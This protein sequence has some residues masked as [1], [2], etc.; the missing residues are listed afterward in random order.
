MDLIY[1]VEDIFSKY[2]PSGKHFVIPSYQRGYKWK[3]KDIEQLLNDIDSFQTH[4]NSTV[5]YCLQ[6]I[7]LVKNGDGNYNVVDG[8]QRLTTLTLLLAHLNKS[9]LVEGKLQYD[10]R[11]ETMR[12]LTE[13]VLNRNL[14]GFRSNK[15][16]PNIL[17]LEWNELGIADDDEYNFQ[18]IFYMYNACKTIEE[19]FR[20]HPDKTDVMREKIL[21]NVKLIVNLPQ[22]STLQEYDLFDN[23]NGKRVTLDGAD[24]IRAMI[25]TRA[26]RKEVENID[27][28][29]KHDVILNE[30]RVKNGLILDDINAWWS[31]K[32]RQAYF[33]QFTKNINSRGENIQFEDSQYPIDFLYKLIVQT[34]DGQKLLDIKDNNLTNGTGTIKLQFFENTRNL[35]D[36]FLFIQDIHRLMQDWYEDPVLY[37]LIMFSAVH[38]GMSFNELTTLWFSQNRHSFVLELKKRIRDADFIKA[39]L[40]TQDENENNQD[41]RSLN[42]NEDWYGTEE[43]IPVMVLLDIIRILKSKS[44]FPIANLDA[45][46]FN[47]YVEDKEHI[48]PQTPLSKDFGITSLKDYIKIAYRC[49]F[50]RRKERQNLD[51]ALQ[52]VDYYWN[53]ISQNDLFREWFNNLMT[54]TIIP[55][56]SLGNVCLLNGKVNKSYGN[57]PYPKK[58]FEIMKKSANGEYIRPHVLDAFSKVFADAKRREDTEYML[59]WDLEDIQSRRRHIVNEINV[60]LNR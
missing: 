34:E 27:D 33:R 26:A 44:T 41:E 46:L 29:T 6:N 18:D 11:K 36:L 54:H 47:A 59:Q 4:G 8:Q 2:L 14:H 15:E 53:R 35:C 25:I 42:F 13:Y 30:N 19:W 23:L 43:M 40:R 51:W 21:H 55:L 60:F 32:K 31:N 49:G 58:H 16:H 52:L 1:S 48:F 10:I 37:H 3:T 24:L 22:I 9:N 50:K 7:T 57:A 12:F 20:D 56:N 17:L 28:V 39:V 38:L 5:F 45:K